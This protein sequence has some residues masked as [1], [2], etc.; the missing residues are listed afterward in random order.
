MFADGAT[1]VGGRMQM[2]KTLW[3]ATQTRQTTMEM[4]PGSVSQSVQLIVKAIQQT[5]TTPE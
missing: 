1:T 4:K 2:W 3:E 5:N